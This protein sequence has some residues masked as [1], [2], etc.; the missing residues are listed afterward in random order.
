MRTNA[1]NRQAFSLT[2]SLEVEILLKKP[3]TK[4]SRLFHQRSAPL[5]KPD[6]LLTEEKNSSKIFGNVLVFRADA[7]RHRY[8]EARPKA[9]C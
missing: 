7:R 1:G 6:S 2:A 3:A 9:H 5:R 4:A 8:L